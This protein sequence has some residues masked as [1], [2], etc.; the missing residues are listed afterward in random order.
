VDL[1]EDRKVTTEQGIQLAKELDVPFFEASARAVVNVDEMFH[2]MIWEII[3]QESLGNVLQ[4][5]PQKAQKK[6]CSVM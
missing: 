1:A 4:S 6:N 3:Y 2:K 5:K